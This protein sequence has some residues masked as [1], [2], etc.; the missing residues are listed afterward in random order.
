[1]IYVFG[2][3]LL[4]H[5]VRSKIDRRGVLERA[6]ERMWHNNDVYSLGVSVVYRKIMHSLNGRARPRL[7]VLAKKSGSL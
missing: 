1:M 5:G 7:R 3:Y 4:A 6:S 2:S